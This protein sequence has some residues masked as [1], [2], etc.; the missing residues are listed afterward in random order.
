MEPLDKPEPPVQSKTQQRLAALEQSA[1][2]LTA[3]LGR[4]RFNF[5]VQKAQFEAE[6]A[7]IM[8]DLEKHGHA[9]GEL[10]VTT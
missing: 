5:L 3:Q 4:A 10:R 6:E 2:V 7:R 9:I 1:Q 8:A